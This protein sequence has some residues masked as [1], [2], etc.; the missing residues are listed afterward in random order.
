[1]LFSASADG[2]VLQW[3]LHRG[4]EQAEILLAKRVTKESHGVCV[5]LPAL[6]A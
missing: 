6:P 1:M 4:L 5:V 3:S 2:R